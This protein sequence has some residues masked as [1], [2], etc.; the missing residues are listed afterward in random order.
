M[1][2]ISLYEHHHPIPVADALFGAPDVKSEEGQIFP[3][4][5]P[6]LNLTGTGTAT[7]GKSPIP[8]L[9]SRLALPEPAPRPWSVSGRARQA[10][11]GL[12]GEPSSAAC[13]R[14]DQQ[15]EAFVHHP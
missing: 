3:I 4:S 14:K 2:L 13:R 10:I 8:K 7:G 9:K 5:A 1:N 11:S 12:H 6:N 15:S